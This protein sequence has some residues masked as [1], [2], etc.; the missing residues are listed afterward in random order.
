MTR[1][2]PSCPTPLVDEWFCGSTPA[3]RLLTTGKGTTA[4]R[5]PLQVWYCPASEARESPVNRAV[6]RL[7]SRDDD[8][9]WYGPVVVMKFRGPRR[10]DYTD[11]DRRELPRL[12]KF[13]RT[14]V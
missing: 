5:R 8:V 7:M 6:M 2:G 13:F 14:R 3:I 11:A 4:L 9:V 10:K 1:A 12:S